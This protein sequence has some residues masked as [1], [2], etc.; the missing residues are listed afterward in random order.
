VTHIPG[1]EGW[2][3]HKTS[4]EQSIRT[5]VHIHTGFLKAT[6]RCCTQRQHE[7]EKKT[8]NRREL[9]K[10]GELTGATMFGA[11]GGMN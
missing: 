1:Q 6:Y 7:R 11:E 5:R 4:D 8:M 2:C 3:A 9:L 10:L